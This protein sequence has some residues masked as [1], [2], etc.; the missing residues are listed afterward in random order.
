MMLSLWDSSYESS[1]NTVVAMTVNTA[2]GGKFDLHI[3]QR[4]PLYCN[5]THIA[6]TTYRTTAGR[7]ESALVT[8]K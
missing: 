5:A 4:C 1:L 2:T 6:N 3:V 8:I 7:N